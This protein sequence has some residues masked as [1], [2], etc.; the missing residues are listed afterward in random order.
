MIFRN[1]SK[2]LGRSW[3]IEEDMAAINLKSLGR[4][5]IEEIVNSFD[6]ILADCDGVLWLQ[7]NPIANAANVMNAF[8]NTGKRI[9]Y[10]TNNSTKS[11][12][13]FVAKAKN[14]G[15]IASTDSVL[16]TSY[17]AAK[18]L[19][20]INFDKKVYTIGSPGITKELDKAGISYCG[21]GPDPVN[22]NFTYEESF[23][24]DPDV[25]AV[26]VGFDLHFNYMKMLKAATYLNNKDILFIATNTD[27][28]FPASETLVIPGTGSIVRSIETCSER[29]ATIMGKPA[30]YAAVMLQNKYKIDPKRTLMIGDRANTDILF[31]KRCGFK[32]LLVLTGVSNTRDIDNWK[33]SND[34][35]DKE[36]IPDYYTQTIGDILPHIKN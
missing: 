32:T 24:P 30:P 11:R 18:Y 2:L 31:G 5:K 1:F 35:N 19:Q 34:P 26:L 36:L 33:K 4:E 25:G 28:R 17:L 10:V 6:T 23:T 29:E 12:E 8:H 9:F 27:E 22:E 20:D 7:N 13:E 16:C 15:F 3:S 21:V 14:L